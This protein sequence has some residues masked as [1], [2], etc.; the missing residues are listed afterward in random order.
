[1][2]EETALK[3]AGCKSFGG[4]IPSSSAFDLTIN[5]GYTINKQGGS[6]GASTSQ[7]GRYPN[8]FTGTSL[9]HWVRKHDVGSSPT[10]PTFISSQNS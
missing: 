10:L 9:I 4:S 1:M 3:A 7:N 6:N 8:W 2:D 5:C